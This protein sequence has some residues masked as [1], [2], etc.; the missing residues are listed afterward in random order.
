[1][2]NVIFVAPFPVET[3][4][5]F[6]RACARL[7]GI[8]L[9][10]IVAKAPSGPQAA[11]FHDLAFV[12]DPLDES[13][14]I[15]AA[16]LLERRHGQI[17]RI[18]GILEPLQVALAK[19]RHVLGVPGPTPDVA[20]LFR[21]K[22]RM[23][24]ELRRHGLPCA[25]HKVITQFSDATSFVEEVGF[26]I[27]IKP[28]AGMGC[29]ATWRIRNA[30]ELHEALQAIGASPQ[31]PAIAEEFLKGREYSFETITIDGEVQFSSFTRYFPT[32]LE[33][34]ENPW[35]QWAV[36]HPRDI[37]GP[38]FDDARQLGIRAVK[39]LGLDTGF[40]HMEWFRRHDGTLAIG[41]IAARP[42]GAQIVVGNNYVHNHDFYFSWAR[43]VIDNA[44]DGP[45]ERHFSVGVAFLRGIGHGRVM[46]I[47][48]V[49]EAN[50]AVGPLVVESHL[51]R[52][53]SPRSDSYEGD[54]FIILRHPDT[55]VV[56]TAVKKVIETVKI[57]YAE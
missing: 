18:V 2:R 48:G 53:G 14:L 27:V 45:F 25:R 28:T 4:Y 6:V 33:V 10:G 21:D 5:R 35:I 1:M 16:R 9:L 19:A 56:K 42:P 39:A 32:P 41:E 20:D 15:N 47:T 11:L 37:T 57:H 3:T 30:R 50:R 17:H 55:E 12:Q 36:V 22:G 40:T 34:F 31:N 13:E 46:G 7:Q 54:G 38:E 44:F 49:D 24:D 26:P 23:K 29:K 43:A 8:R 51:P 52:P